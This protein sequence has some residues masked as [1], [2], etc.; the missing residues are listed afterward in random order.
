MKI[1]RRFFLGVAAFLSA[2]LIALAP[3]LSAAVNSAHAS[4]AQAPVTPFLPQTALR[5]QWDILHNTDLSAASRFLK[6]EQAQQWFVENKPSV[7]GPVF[8][9]ALTIQEAQDLL[10]T[11]EDAT[12]LRLV[13]LARGKKSWQAMDALAQKSPALKRRM[14]MVRWEWDTLPL[15]IKE[16]LERAGKTQ[17]IWAECSPEERHAFIQGWAAG[18]W[19]EFMSMA[20]KSEAA[21]Q[22]MR[23]LKDRIWA[24]LQP[25]GRYQ[26]ADQL[27][28][29]ETAVKAFARIEAQLKTTE[30]TPW[31]PLAQEVRNAPDLDHMLAGLGALFDKMG[32]RDAHLSALRPALP[33]E[34]FTAEQ[35]TRLEKRLRKSFA[36]RIRGTLSGDRVRQFYKSHPLKFS[37]SNENDTLLARHLMG[38]ITF[39]SRYI[40]KFI[41]AN[42]SKPA[43]I[44]SDQNLFNQLAQLLAPYFIHETIHAMQYA[45]TQRELGEYFELVKDKEIEAFLFHSLYALE[46]I[47]TSP[48]FRQLLGSNAPVENLSRRAL[49]DALALESNP[50]EFKKKVVRNHV[51]LQ[52]DSLESLTFNLAQRDFLDF[53]KTDY[54]HTRYSE[55]QYRQIRPPGHKNRLTQFKDRTTRQL[56]QEAQDM[57]DPVRHAMKVYALCLK[58]F[59]SAFAE[60]K[61]RLAQLSTERPR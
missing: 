59:E 34:T 38:H 25:D 21:L 3:A 35:A 48:A 14:A 58:R 43:D 49:D 54:L 44:F 46:K 37:V 4:V 50:G 60:V 22:K 61:Q 10:E 18:P 57:I 5:Y 39:N 11:H 31:A 45:W 15:E 2:A 28:K 29:S 1:K 33:E 20:P 19:K 40:V 24:A 53:Y 52:I 42:G 23:T 7:A 17:K 9:Q 26:A 51:Y 56:R 36:R 13:M 47:R 8:S 32:I 6:D 27:E 16:Y 12:D 30:Q 41:K 55:L